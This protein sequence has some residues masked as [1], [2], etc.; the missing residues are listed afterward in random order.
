ME[1]ESVTVT[2][3]GQV[4]TLNVGGTVF[5]TTIATLTKYPNS[6]LAAMFNQES[7]RPPARKDDN[8]N[9]FIDAEPEPFKFILRF[10]R[11]GKLSAY[12]DGRTLEQLEWEADYYGLEEL[13]KLIRMR[14][15]EDDARPEATF[16]FKLT[17]FSQV[18]EYVLSPAI[19]VRNLPWKMMIKP[20]QGGGNPQTGTWP[21]K[22][23]GYFLQ[24]NEESKDSSWSCQA[25]VKL[26][27]LSVVPGN[28]AFS[29][30]ISHL[31]YW[32]ENCFGYS[33]YMKWADVVD[34]KKGFIKDDTVTLQ[35]HV[36]A[37]VPHGV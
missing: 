17:N 12:I 11:R 2:M 29:R 34:P 33:H 1:F 4:I 37:D 26:K 30:K 3:S 15:D 20:T 7:E 25:Q 24:C 35:V 6:L 19:M 32:K 36:K 28:T 9:F 22:S 14:R 27:V 23:M 21:N 5:T 16:T 8:G 10:L 13:L 18:K 31:F